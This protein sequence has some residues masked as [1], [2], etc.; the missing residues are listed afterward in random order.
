[1]K[2]SYQVQ[3]FYKSY[4]KLPNGTLTKRVVENELSLVELLN[5]YILLEP[6]TI[7]NYKDYQ[8]P[9]AIKSDDLIERI[10][11]L[12]F[13]QH[14]LTQHFEPLITNLFWRCQSIKKEIY[15]DDIIKQEMETITNN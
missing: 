4:Q 6:I 2:T 10:T 8:C 13:R 7:D 14:A 12:R 5:K 11:V 1:M 15:I 9:E 3:I